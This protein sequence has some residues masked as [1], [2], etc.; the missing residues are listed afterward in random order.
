MYVYKNGTYTA[1]A[2]GYDGDVEV[3]IT[4]E[5]DVITN[6]TGNTYESDPWYFDE[7]YGPVASQILSSQSTDVDSV[8]GATYS[9]EAIMSAVA[10][11]LDSARS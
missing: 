11:A 10:A 2:Y 9:S 1:K 6:I 5:N 7:A 3:T 4:I 8:S